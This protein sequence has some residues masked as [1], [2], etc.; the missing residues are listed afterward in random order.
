MSI[1]PWFKCYPDSFLRGL[2]GMTIDEQAFYTQIVM[3]NYDHADALY[4]DDKTI[5]RWCGSNA[6]KW[7]RVKDSLMAQGRIY[8]LPDGGLIDE[9]AL[10][11]MAEICRMRAAKVSPKIRKR[12]AKLEQCLAKH[13]QII[14]KTSPKNRLNTTLLKEEEKIKEGKNF[15]FDEFGV[16]GAALQAACHAQGLDRDFE[17][18]WSEAL[19]ACDGVI[20]VGSD[21]VKDRY[22]ERLGRVLRSESIKIEVQGKTP[23]LRVVAGANQNSGE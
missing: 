4:A 13:M 20:Y 18:L 2:D 15:D 23:S 6:R 21:W 9:R 16:V 5:A 17:Q 7:L 12:I 19:T 1:G 11:E 22:S 8:E 3:R 10:D 14:S